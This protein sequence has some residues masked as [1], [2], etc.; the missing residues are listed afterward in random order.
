MERYVRA[1]DGAKE[2]GKKSARGAGFIMLEQVANTVVQLASIAILT[3]LLTAA[4][5]GINDGL[6]MV[7]GFL[8]IFANLG[9][10]I[11]IIQKPD[12]THQQASNLFWINFAFSSSLGILLALCSGLLAGFF[13]VPELRNLALLISPTFAISGAAVAHDALMQRRM[14]YNLLAYRRVIGVFV[15]TFTS[16]VAAFFGLGY[17]SITLGLVV[18]SVVTTTLLWV[19]SPWRPAWYRAGV[20]TKAL[21]LVGRNLTVFNFANYFR[22]NADKFLILLYMS[23][24]A[25]GIYQRGFRFLLFPLQ[26]TTYPLNSLLLSNLSKLTE[27]PARLA[28]VYRKQVAPIALV[29]MPA[30]ATA[31]ALSDAIVDVLMGEEFA[32]VGTIFFWLGLMGALSVVAATTAPLMNAC[33]NSLV[34]MRL[35]IV[36]VFITI[37]AFVLAV[38][39]GI[40]GMAIAYFL[41]NLLLSP[42]SF[43]LATR[44]TPVG[45]SD[46]ADI[47]L[48]PGLLSLGII[49]ARL[50]LG[51][52]MDLE[53][54]AYVAIILSLSVGGFGVIAGL[55]PR[56]RQ[57]LLDAWELAK[58]A[59]K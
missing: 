42:V 6:F 22:N 18:A 11:A 19:L 45:G 4:E 26:R 51:Q 33:G 21:A 10:G 36:R 56:Q 29:V 54:P 20:G 32:Q 50:F 59:K 38:P 43:L 40:E 12:L 58:Q 5:Y 14:E 23:E 1:E 27:E 41:Q 31:V 7:T 17:Y 15:G 48:L 57:K 3:R 49:G 34:L 55:M 28:E 30:V 25:L 53:S 39:Y 52:T 35:S 46:W 47:L 16:I 44:Y 13:S 8:G 24:G 2:L 37:G 9:F